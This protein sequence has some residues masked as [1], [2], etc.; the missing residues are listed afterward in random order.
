MQDFQM[1]MQDLQVE[2][3]CPICHTKYKTDSEAKFCAK[4]PVQGNFKVG[5]KV[6]YSEFKNRECVVVGVNVASSV[7]NRRT[8]QSHYQIVCVEN[9]YGDRDC[10]PY[11][12]FN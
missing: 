1:I 5:D 8:G 11:Y 7:W 12:Y 4:N 6:T 3:E 9:E 2:F 10:K